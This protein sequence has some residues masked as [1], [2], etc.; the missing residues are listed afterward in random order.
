MDNFCKRS[1]DI[2]VLVFMI[3]DTEGF[4]EL[5]SYKH[6][7]AVTVAFAL[8]LQEIKMDHG[9]K[10]GPQI[11]YLSGTWKEIAVFHH[12]FPGLQAEFL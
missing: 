9:F 2:R 5:A 10:G 4:K 7:Q 6:V 12:A 11:L 3:Q 8:I 1:Q